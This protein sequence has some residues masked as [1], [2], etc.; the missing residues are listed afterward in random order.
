[1]RELIAQGKKSGN[2][3]PKGRRVGTDHSP[4]EE[5]REQIAKGKKSGNRQTKGRRERERENQ[6]P[7]GTAERTDRMRGVRNV[8]KLGDARKAGHTELQCTLGQM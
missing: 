4:R 2:R 8:R 6:E 5:E 1:M 3:Q 7:E